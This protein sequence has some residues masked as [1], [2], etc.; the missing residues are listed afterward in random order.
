MKKVFNYLHAAIIWFF[1]VFAI[2]FVMAYKALQAGFTHLF[3][4]VDRLFFFNTIKKEIYMTI[5]DD[6][7]AIKAA[8][9]NPAPVTVDLSTV[10]KADV[11]AAVASDVTAI[12][13][14]LTLTPV[15]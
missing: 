1:S 13:A 3:K 8:V 4:E 5:A 2:P 9:L 6:I 12:K 7:A 14:D 11:L 15:S 10:A